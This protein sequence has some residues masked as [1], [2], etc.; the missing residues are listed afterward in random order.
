MSIKLLSKRNIMLICLL[1]MR[2]ATA[3]GAYD[4]EISS[5]DPTATSWV[6][7]HANTCLLEDNTHRIAANGECLAI[8]TYTDLKKP[9]K[10]N[11]RLLVYIHGD[12]IPGG[13]PSDNLKYQASKHV[14]P[15]ATNVVVIRP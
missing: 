8:Q 4:E 13:G 2:A 3:L 9:P 7:H 1:T 5:T 10:P 11:G 12:G 6:M 15:D 14:L